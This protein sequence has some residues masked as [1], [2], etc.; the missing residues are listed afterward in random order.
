M[1]I[2]IS[3]I[4]SAPTLCLNMI[5]KNEG[6]IITRLFDSVLPII[7]CYCIC[8]TGST[9]NTKELIS[10]YFESK[11]IPGKIVEE[12]FVDFAHNRNFALQSCFGMSDYVLLLDADM[13]LEIKPAFNKKILKNYD[14]FLI[15]QGNENFY[16][17]NMRIVRNNS[18][19]LYIGVTHEYISTPSTNTSFNIEKNILFINDVGDGGA[20]SD[21]SERDIRLLKK[22]IEDNPNS[23]RYHF[24]LANTYF[25]IG[26]YDDAIENYNKRIKL[27]GWV[28][29][30]WFSYYKIGL[31]YKNMGKME[32]AIFTW[33]EGY[34]YF[35]NRIENL[36]EIIQHYRIVGKCKVAHAFYK[37]AKESLLK[38]TDKDTYLFLSNDVYTYKLEYELSILSC[39]IGIS[40]INDQAVT[41][42]NHCNAQG[43]INNTLSNM[44][45]YKDILKPLAVINYSSS[46]EHDIANKKRNMNSS[47]T[48]II[49]Y[50]NGYLMNMRYVNYYIKPNGYYSECEDFI[51]TVNKYVE[52]SKDFKIINEK[53][54]DSVF[55]NRRFIGIE[56]V[57]IYKNKD[58]LVFMGTGLLKNGNIGVCSGNYDKNKNY[59]ES[60]ELKPNFT[61]SECEKNW[62][63]VNLNDELHVIYGWSPLQ[64]C[65]INTATNNLELVS[66]IENMPRFFKQM[67]GSSSAAEYKDELWFTTHIVSYEQP[68]HYYHALVVFDKSM[69]LLRY[70]A[71]FKFEGECIE[72]SIGLIVE[73]DRVIIPYSTWDRTTKLAIYDKKYID[74]IVKYT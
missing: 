9:D 1:D 24:Y 2:V 35:P 3:E 21:K 54:I 42:F 44:K 32:Q 46:F 68:R 59:M 11:G 25:D 60:V 53:L 6:K 62:V 66:K 47:S 31:A 71:P 8:D 39:Y 43:T 10:E 16:Y 27:G 57:R 26:K 56:D 55:D 37:M 33:L 19:Y 30:V 20:K 70:S 45:F 72:Y 69:K 36:Y 49:P 34:N 48:S 40:N 41:I 73:D 14:S 15:L 52:L 64:I 65:K 23:D 29:E 17:N 18:L 7:D 5:V 4:D 63:Y 28:Q 74:S 22:G 50:N 13:I 51:V 58:N 38:A 61:N 12:P 67:R